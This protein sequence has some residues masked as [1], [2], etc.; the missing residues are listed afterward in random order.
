MRWFKG[1][2]RRIGRA[3]GISRPRWRGRTGDWVKQRQRRSGGGRKR[4]QEDG[5]LQVIKSRGLFAKQSAHRL[6]WDG[7]SIRKHQISKL[8]QIQ[9]HGDD[10]SS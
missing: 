1:G 4:V 7:G 3:T 2:V 9:K 10:H 6:F 8:D 5:F